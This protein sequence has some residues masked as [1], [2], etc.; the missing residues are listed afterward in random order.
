MNVL[1][2]C[3]RNKRRSPTAES[4]FSNLEGVNVL[5]AGTSVDAETPI[6]ADLIEWADL[7]LAI[8]S[9]HR[10]RIQQRFGT[11][12]RQKKIAVLGIPDDYEY[13]DEELVR[14]LH[15]AVTSY[16]RSGGL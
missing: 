7:I 10:R 12:L 2:V 6:S 14:R 1:F 5:S 11:L 16:L 8:E 13:G 15:K 9:V 3:S 4:I